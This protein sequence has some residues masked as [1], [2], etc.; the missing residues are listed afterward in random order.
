MKKAFQITVKGKVQGV[1]FRASTKAVADQLGVKGNVKNLPN[2]DVFI[3]AE[4]D[5]VFEQDFLEW[6]KTGPDEAQVTA[7]EVKEAELKNFI[8]FEILKR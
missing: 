5:V 2:G 3:E 7:V 8:N 6:C 4:V 1:F